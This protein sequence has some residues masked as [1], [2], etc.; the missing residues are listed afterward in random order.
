MHASIYYLS[1]TM[2]SFNNPASTFNITT[3]INLSPKP[4]APKSHVPLETPFMDLF[5]LQ[6]RLRCFV[7]DFRLA[8]RSCQSIRLPPLSQSTYVDID[9]I[10][11]WFRYA[12]SCCIA[13]DTLF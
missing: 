12:I 6:S 13:Q 8:I 10:R 5:V 1:D 7:L 4:P 9:L 3:L 11:T 2:I